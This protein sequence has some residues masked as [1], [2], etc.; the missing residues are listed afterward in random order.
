MV[1]TRSVARM[2]KIPLE[3]TASRRTGNRPAADSTARGRK[4]G[5]VI[6]TTAQ[7][8]LARW[9]SSPLPAGRRLHVGDVSEGGISKPGGVLRHALQYEGVVAVAGPAVTDAQG[10]ED[11]N[12]LPELG[13]KLD[14][15]L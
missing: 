9:S 4:R 12:R 13:A 2:G 6:V 11:H 15:P 1:K 10:L 14:R 7:A 5:V 8:R 3:S